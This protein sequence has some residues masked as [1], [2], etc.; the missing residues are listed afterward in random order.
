MIVPQ[1]RQYLETA[2]QALMNSNYVVAERDLKFACEE[3]PGQCDL[4]RARVF[5]R[6]RHHGGHTT[7]AEVAAIWSSVDTFDEMVSAMDPNMIEEWFTTSWTMPMIPVHLMLITRG[8]V[9]AAYAAALVES[10][11][12]D[13]ARTEL[14]T[15]AHER[16][17]RIENVTATAKQIATVECLLYYRTARWDDLLRAS[18]TLTA[19]SGTG[20]TEKV[21]AALGNAMGGTALAHMGSHDAGQTKLR[22]A[23]S[24]GYS[25]VSAWASLEL[26]LSYRAVGDE[27]SA[28]KVLGEGMQYDTLPELSDALRNKSVRMRTSTPEVIAAR[29]SFWDLS[30][31]PDVVDYQRQSSQDER[32]EVL[33]DALA[34]LDAMDGMDAIKEQMHTLSSEI[35]FENEQRRRGMKVKPKTRH[36]IFRGPPGTGKTTIAN[37][38]VRLYYGLGVIRSHTMV[39]AN[40]ATLVGTV[41]GQSAEKTLAK[42]TEA[43]GGIIFIDEAYELVQDRGGQADPY[44]S[45]VLTTLLEYMDNNRDDLIVIV[46]GYA[47]PMERFLGENPG[48]KSRFAYSL[49]FNTYSP[50]EMWRILTGMALKEGRSVDLSIED[51]FRQVIE[52]MWDHDQHGQR[53]LD[54]AGNGRFARNVFEQA[55]GLASRRLMAAGTGLSTLTDEQL[56]QLT[57]EDVLGAMSNILKG[58][59]MVNVA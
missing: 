26:G 56:T 20:D 36:L 47:G 57:A 22:Y 2:I 25:A 6:I 24:A 58:F 30:T 1:A 45:E 52:V 21:L 11:S 54:V 37:L 46:A 51:K 13:Q 50:D 43:R 48:L 41:E 18:S 27:E 59:G 15:A 8:Q 3:W 10:G 16:V 53:V 5:T 9:R 12:Y 32:R 44:G 39:L 23:I 17:V 49:S 19:G 35:M 7:A 4:H 28:Q 33:A 34:E 29:T 55:Q 40:R 42:L 31:E 14:D 38:I